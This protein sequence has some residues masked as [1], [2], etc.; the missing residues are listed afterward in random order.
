MERSTS[1][2]LIY[3]NIN[4]MKRFF[5]V[6][7]VIAHVA[8]NGS[9]GLREVGKTMPLKTVAATPVKVD[10]MINFAWGHLSENYLV[11]QMYGRG[12][13]LQMWSWPDLNL[14]GEYLNRG[15]GEGEFL[16]VNWCKSAQKDVVSIYDV[17]NRVL[18]SYDIK[19][20]T[21]TLNREYSLFGEVEGV[22]I[23]KPYVDALQ[24]D[25]ERFILRSSDASKDELALVNLSTQEVLA[26]YEDIMERDADAD[27]YLDYN[28]MMDGTTKHIVKAYENLNRIDVLQLKR[29]DI[30]AKCV[31]IEGP[32]VSNDDHCYY[33]DVVCSEDIFLCLHNPLGAQNSIIEIYDYAGNMLGN[34]D[35]GMYFTNIEYDALRGEILCYNGDSDENLFYVVKWKK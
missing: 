31:I 26:V 6:F 5:I 35:V 19:E 22:G 12:H 16:A 11:T 30:A 28:Y 21:V 14:V 33:M 18:R 10:S 13:I 4:N 15:R 25:D 34:L 8:C 24:I 20:G 29:N 17:P 9:S 1:G 27:Q 32:Q 2:I 23:L 3:K 7:A